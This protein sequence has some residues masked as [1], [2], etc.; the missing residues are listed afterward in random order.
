MG[1][2][3]WRGRKTGKREASDF[4]PLRTH[5]V[6]HEDVKNHVLFAPLFNNIE[7]PLQRALRVLSS[8]LM[9]RPIQGNL[10]VEPDCDEI[11]FGLNE[12]KCFAGTVSNV[13]SCG[14]QFNVESPYVGVRESCEGPYGQ[15]REE[16]PAG[17]GV[18]TDY[19]LYVNIAEG[20]WNVMQRWVYD[21]GICNT[22]VLLNSYFL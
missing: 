3:H 20:K 16:G 13:Y 17:Y 10:T 21:I 15:C 4:S 9:V 2:V 7:S 1:H 8:S 14:R 18:S 22:N 6:Y 19:I 12:G 5:V 11:G